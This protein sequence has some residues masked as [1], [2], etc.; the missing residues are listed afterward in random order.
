METIKIS[1]KDFKKM[2]ALYQDF[3]EIYGNQ[4]TVWNVD[5]LEEM[6]KIGQKFIDI[7]SVNFKK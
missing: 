4:N 1:K 5:D 2:F 7:F 6:R 3:Y